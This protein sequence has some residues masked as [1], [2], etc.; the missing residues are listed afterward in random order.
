MRGLTLIHLNLTIESFSGSLAETGVGSRYA[1]GKS[2]MTRL[3]EH[4]M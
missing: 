4:R 3:L 2:A 1:L